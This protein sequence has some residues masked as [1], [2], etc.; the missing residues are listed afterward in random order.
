MFYVVKTLHNS[1]F[2]VFM[3]D[4]MLARKL[5]NVFSIMKCL[6]TTIVFI[7]MKEFI[8]ERNSMNVSNVVKTLCYG[9]PL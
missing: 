2:I 5:M 8:L 9:N 3:K 6:Y 1:V 4:Y 7:I